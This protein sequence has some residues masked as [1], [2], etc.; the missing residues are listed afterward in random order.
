MMD[1]KILK[2]P[3]DQHPDL[4]IT[5]RRRVDEY[6]TVN[7]ISRNWNAEMLIKTI[8]MVAIYIIPY[9][10]MLTGRFTN[11]WIL[12]LMWVIMGIGTAGIGLCIMHDANHGAY[13][14][15]PKVNKVLGYFLNFV[16]GSAVNWRMQHNMLHHS[17][18]NISGYDE[19]IGPQESLLRFS[20][21]K[22]LYKAHRYQHIYAWFLYSLMTIEWVLWRDFPQLI[23][24]HKMGLTV[25][26]K[27][28]FSGLLTELIIS[29]IIYFSYI[30]VIPL[31]FMPIAWWQMIIFFFTMHLIGGFI[32]AI[33][34]QPAHVI[35][36]SLY[37]LPNEE[38][39]LEN[40]WAIHQFL[41]TCDFAPH[42]RIFSWFVGG[43]NY[44]VEHHIFPYICHVHYR[45]ISNIVKATVQEYGVPYNV[46]P[47]YIRA[48]IEH[49][50]MLRNLGRFEKLEMAL[51]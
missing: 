8:V 18:T 22:P 4:I 29:K 19:D 23:R 34:F 9:I 39:K 21:H 13:S 6:F 38:G 31:I 11:P 14:R 16:G 46:Q 26:S 10:L 48:L 32:L 15:N 24:Y 43:L 40:N 35:P 12:F 3:N 2:F 1:R 17:F 42:S 47:T 41:T 37:P 50:R 36:S 30:V 44:Q 45:K 25:G 7:N 28:K 33:I 5:L 49:G 51:I 20:P 27:K